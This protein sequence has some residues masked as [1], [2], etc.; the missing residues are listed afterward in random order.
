MDLVDMGKRIRR[1]RI[2]KSMTQEQLAEVTGLSV[3]YIGMIERGERTPSLETFIQIADEL[4]ATADELLCGTMQEGY[5]LRMSRY[6]EQVAKMS[7]EE[8][9]KFYTVVDALLG[10]S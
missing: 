1:K 7:L 2:S 4:N 5:Q 6:E 3:P 10:M 8:R 9:K